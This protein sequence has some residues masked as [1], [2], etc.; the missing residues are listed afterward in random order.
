[1]DLWRGSVTIPA[2]PTQQSLATTPPPSSATT[3]PPSS[4]PIL[5]EPKIAVQPGQSTR[6]RPVTFRRSSAKRTRIGRRRRRR[7]FAHSLLRR[8][9]RFSVSTRRRL[10][11]PSTTR[12]TP[13]TSLLISKGIMVQPRQQAALSRSG[14]AE[15]AGS[16]A[17]PGAV[18]SDFDV[19]T[20]STTSCD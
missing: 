19:H 13:P 20:S 15:T 16:L 7:R 3:P 2:K 17:C 8:R 18:A 4:T 6:V 5:V 1:M 14:Q 11:S 12:P 9:R 10:R